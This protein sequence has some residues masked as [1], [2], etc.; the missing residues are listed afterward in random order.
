MN[1]ILIVIGIL[2]I[3]GGFFFIFRFNNNEK[4]LY[5]EIEKK[6]KEIKEYAN[7]VEKITLELN[8]VLDFMINNKKTDEEVNLKNKK[9]SN[10]FNATENKKT[11]LLNSICDN[12]NDI[13]QEIIRLKR[14]GI[15]NHEIARQVGKSIREVEI[16]LKLINK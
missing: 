16:I 13:G 9:T 12:T 7:T 8:E 6:H 3:L 5:I 10:E 2:S 1:S 4:E 15:E 11:E 14:N